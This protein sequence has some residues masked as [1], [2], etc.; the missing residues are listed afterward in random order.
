MCEHE[1]F[2]SGEGRYDATSRTLRYVVVCEAC[3]EE[4]REVSIETY[5]PKFDPAG[6]DSF[7]KAA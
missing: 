6:N 4:V 5:A 3:R 1:G 2:H 7:L